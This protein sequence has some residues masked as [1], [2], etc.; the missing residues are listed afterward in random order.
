MRRSPCR[1]RRPPFKGP[2]PFGGHLDS[3]SRRLRP[4]ACGL[5]CTVRLLFA[6]QISAYR[7]RDRHPC[8]LC[9]CSFASFLFVL[10][11]FILFTASVAV[12]PWS[13]DI[14][15]GGWCPSG[16]LYR[17]GRRSCGSVRDAQTCR[18]DDDCHPSTNGA[19]RASGVVSDRAPGKEMVV[20]TADARA[21]LHSMPIAVGST[22]VASPPHK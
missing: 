16:V 7:Q 3:F 21:R 10:F 12:Q 19:G 8:C 20:V 5:R 22:A 15:T 1:S 18:R 14:T 9:L 6:L 13:G 2:F 4:A 17:F 11:Y